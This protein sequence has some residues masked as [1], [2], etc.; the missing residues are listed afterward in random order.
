MIAR[1]YSARLMQAT[2]LAL[3]TG[4]ALSH[5]AQAQ[6]A[7]VQP[8]AHKSDPDKASSTP[9]IIVTAPQIQ[10]AVVSDIPP[11][12]ELDEAAVESYGASSIAELLDAL[13]PQTTSGRG[14]DS[15]G[16]V[17]LLNGQR[18]S[19]F[20]EIRDLPPEAILRVQILPEEVALK[21]GY[22]ADQ[23]VVNFILKSDFKSVTAEGKYSQSTNGGG[24]Q[25]EFDTT[26][27]RINKGARTSLTVD[28]N[29]ADSVF[30]S[31]RDIIQ[32][33]TGQSASLAGNV[34]GTTFGGQVD[35]VLSVIA[36]VPVTSAAVPGSLGN[37][38]PALADF[39]ATAN[40]PGTTDQGDYRTLLPATDDIKIN[41][42]IARPLTDKISLS[43]NGSYELAKGRSFFG[44]SSAAVTIPVG[45][46]YS[47]F[48]QPV[49]LVRNYGSALA[50]DT[51][52]DTFHGG[53]TVNGSISKWQWTLTGNYDRI[54]SS[55][56]TDNGVD[57]A[58]L[59]ARVGITDPA[60]ATNPFASSFSAGNGPRDTARSQSDATNGIY[61]ISGPVADL[62]AG[63]IRA[64]IRAGFATQRL[65]SNAER[66]GLTSQADLAR[67]EGNGRINVDIPLTSRDRDFGAAIGNLTL[68]G[69]LAYRHLS[70]FGSLVSF[71]YG[72]NWSP[73]KGLTILGTA[74]DDEAEPSIQQLG[75]PTIQTPNVVTYDYTRGES[76]LV[77][78]ISGGNTALVTEKRRDFK[79]G[80]TYKPPKFTD[81]QLSA[82]FF[83]NR[84]TNPV[85]DFP[86]LTP[87]I[88]RAFP[89][90]VTRDASGRLI[91]IDTR[92]VN[93]AASRSNVLRVGFNFSHSFGKTAN[94]ERG[95]GGG[96]RGGGGGGDG[97]PR[98]G[99][100][101]RGGG[102]GG[103]GG[104]GRGNDQ[105]G[106]WQVSV[107]D[108]IRFL[109]QIVIRP[110]L[111]VLDLLNG[112]AVGSGGSSRHTF[113][114]DAGYFNKGLGLRLKGK[115]LTS[116][117]VLGGMT[118][119]GSTAPDL[120][121]ASLLTLD[122][123][124]FLNFDSRKKLVSAMPFLTG[125]R[126]RLSVDNLTNAIRDV[127]DSNGIVPLS[128]QP[129][130]IDARGRTVQLNFRKK[131]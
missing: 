43:L 11:E 122:A 80:L 95:I 116:S 100:G 45:Q 15:A 72:L 73:I 6:N 94:G 36:G 50:R 74:I 71:G 35:P 38:T 1:K 31:Q 64:T 24:G 63:A 49:T 60:L 88:E 124:A 67:D 61:T 20:S 34:Y 10:G 70:D 53:L 127:R 41:A 101:S 39:A 93:Y 19:S 21:F 55:T 69:N 18:I 84:S 82:N 32:R 106:R 75:N 13:S 77:T 76:V 112:G 113:D 17:I 54:I 79:L 115:Y 98:G 58:A 87:L 47:P 128:Y 120:F 78:Q 51:Q 37:R 33:A 65:S 40:Q 12:L 23:R 91:S 42:V 5:T 26:G 57:V 89:D 96:P 130:L 4:M 109:D 118:G 7:P 81:L 52:S 28:Y 46:P 48:S 2:A 123:Q 14:R 44:L 59:Q 27:V 110:D 3:T 25:S 16:P 125:S 131:F 126:L 86:T 117:T 9:E 114:L 102:G 119:T 104:F 107:Y 92:S 90:R 62:P 121:F 56:G 30:E 66:A 129:G 108:S 85:S 111:P 22:A 29:H 68:N 99:G 105:G 97:G 83:R 103:G 8:S